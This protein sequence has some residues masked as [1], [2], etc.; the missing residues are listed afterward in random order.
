MSIRNTTRLLTHFSVWIALVS[1]IFFYFT[2]KN[3]IT[4]L[5]Q[6][7][8]TTKLVHTVFK[9]TILRD[10]YF[11]NFNDRALKQWKWQNGEL[12]KL[13]NQF[14]NTLKTPEKKNDFTRILRLHQIK[15]RIFQDLTTTTTT[16]YKNL[17]SQLLVVDQSLIDELTTLEVITSKKLETIERKSRSLLEISFL[18]IFL[19]PIIS[20]LWIRRFVT[21]PLHRLHEGTEIIASGDLSHRVGTSTKNEI[22]QLSRSF[23][24]MVAE[25]QRTNAEIESFTYSVAHDL[26]APARAINGFVNIFF[27]E[28]GDKLDEDGKRLL[29][30]I[31]NSSK[32]MGLLTDGLLT[33]FRFGLQKISCSEIDMIQLTKNI[34]E[35]LKAFNPAQNIQF[36]LKEL[37]SIHGD[38]RMIRQVLT[39]L[40][41]NSIKFTK[42]GTAAQ[43]EIGSESNSNEAIYYVKDNGVGFDMKYADKLFGV[44]Q[45]LHTTKEFE[46]SGIGLAL[47]KKIILQHGG[48]VWAEGKINQGATFYFSLPKK[49]IVV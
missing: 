2:E 45:R 26:K 9:L 32:N 30:T 42:P 36:E 33:F 44:F 17:M 3:R 5:E 6:S 37:P 27:E 25:L 11:L 16:F 13:L 46:G 35:E 4:A 10:E 47:V 8:L 38:P 40:L 39:N 28:Y 7:H 19:P 49:P 29:R 12:T 15:Q 18:L 1:L 48:R 31:A 24:R 20:S 14:K 23:D 41:S 43:I 34:F 22:G 21:K